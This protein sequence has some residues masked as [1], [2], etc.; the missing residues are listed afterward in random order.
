MKN[1]EKERID[2][3]KEEWEK[4]LKKRNLTKQSY[5]ENISK[6]KSPKQ[7]KKIVGIQ[8]SIRRAIDEDD[9]KLTEEE[10]QLIT[11]EILTRSAF[12]DEEEYDSR[13]VRSFYKPS[14]FSY[15][16]YDMIVNKCWQVCENEH[17]M[18]NTEF[19]DFKVKFDYI[20]EKGYHLSDVIERP[21]SPSLFRTGL[22]DINDE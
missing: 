4:F 17:S 2:F 18:W 6:A 14:Y 5:S 10:I 16:V 21:G 12:G 22:N 11:K 1:S 3:I 13:L 7:L 8:A 19:E 9:I 20:Y 15:D